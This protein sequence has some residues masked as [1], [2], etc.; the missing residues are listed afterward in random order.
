[1]RKTWIAKIRTDPIWNK[2]IKV[3]FVLAIS[4]KDKDKHRE[5]CNKESHNNSDILILDYE[6]SYELFTIKMLAIM[7]YFLKRCYYKQKDLD[8][9]PKIPLFI[10]V[11]DDSIIFQ[12]TLIKVLNKLKDKI[13]ADRFVAGRIISLSK[14]NMIYATGPLY[15]ISPLAVEEIYEFSRCLTE[16]P[17]F[18]DLV[19]S[20]KVP[21]LLNIAFINIP[22]H[23][24]YTAIP[25]AFS[26]PK[27]LS[28]L[29]YLHDYPFTEG[30]QY[31]IW[32]NVE[33]YKKLVRLQII[34]K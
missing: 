4:K 17:Y 23:S 10:K 14:W 19:I 26:T 7:E 34:L 13:E 31:E 16:L 9:A 8:G 33:N 21:L 32:K 22:G 3:F 28:K 24:C 2:K 20:G 18:D 1:M 29:C 12:N 11:T 25:S 15:C 27:A 30:Q 6:D 5:V